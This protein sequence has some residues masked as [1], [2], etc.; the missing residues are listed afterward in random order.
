[1]VLLV[2]NIKKYIWWRYGTDWHCNR[3]YSVP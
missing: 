3:P 1:M 2:D